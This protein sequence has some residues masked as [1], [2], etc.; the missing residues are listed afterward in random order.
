M[1]VGIGAVARQNVV[2]TVRTYSRQVH[3]VSMA[4]RLAVVKNKCATVRRDGGFPRQAAKLTVRLTAEVQAEIVV[5]Y[6]TGEHSTVLARR[7]GVSK[8]ALLELLREAGVQLRRQPMTPE[9]IEQARQ[10]YERGLSLSQA[11]GQLGIHQDTIRLALKR[12]GVTLRPGG[13]SAPGRPRR[14]TGHVTR[15]DRQVG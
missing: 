13:G 3:L 14:Q 15:A 9:Q 2:G 4:K 5:A 10:L 7:Y 8:T 1:L 12:A 11:S 6:Q